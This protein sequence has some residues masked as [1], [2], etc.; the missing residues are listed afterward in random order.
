MKPSCS[1]DGCGQP[2]KALGF[3]STHWYRNRSG[4]PMDIPIGQLQISPPKG[5]CAID[6]CDTNARSRGLCTVHYR[7][8]LRKSDE[9]VRKCSV[10]G[11]ESNHLAR[12]YCVRHHIRWLRGKEISLPPKLRIDRK[13][14]L[15]TVDGCERTDIVVGKYGQLCKGHT[16]R[17]QRG[18]DL[19]TPIKRDCLPI[20]SV[21]GRN[22]GYVT[23]KVG[24]GHKRMPQ[25]RWVMEQHIGRPLLTHE[26]VHHLNGQRDDN[27][28]ENLELW[29]S[30]QPR[31]QRVEDK[32][33]WCREFMALYATP[34][35][36]PSPSSHHY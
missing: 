31:G 32:L 33:A 3:C 5:P 4:L 9:R 16:G 35:A 7:A 2:I 30:S 1:V 34:P 25:H 15:C 6:G 17:A 23:I 18:A 28:I 11:C 13:G 36:A 8:W 10:D 21:V 20:G 24:Q 22:E 19:S 14:Y 26:N 29:S 27:R 12:G